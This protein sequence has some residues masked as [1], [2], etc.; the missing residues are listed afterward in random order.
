MLTITTSGG[1][2]E[3]EPGYNISFCNEESSKLDHDRVSVGPGI[4]STIG[5][6]KCSEIQEAGSCPT[7]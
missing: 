2:T 3:L 6:F 7:R 4:M 1:N 5:C